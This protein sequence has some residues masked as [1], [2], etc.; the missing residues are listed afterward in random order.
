[1]G[2][3]KKILLLGKDGQVGWELQRALAP[4]G[5]V[6][7]IGR[8]DC[9]LA[10]TSQIVSLVERVRPGAI[11]NP[12]GYTNVDKA[13]SE[14][15]MAYAINATA[16]KVLAAQANLLHIP[17]I[18]FSTDY[19]FDGEKCTPYTEEDTPNPLS[20]Y[21]KTKWQGEKNVAAMCAR[22]VIIRT[23][24]AFGLHGN[25]FLKA[26]LGFARERSELKVVSDQFGAPT[27]ACLLADATAEVLMQLFSD[28]T[29]KYGT[30]HL[31]GGGET[32]WHGYALKIVQLANQLGMKTKIQAEDIQPIPTEKYPLPA[33]RPRSSRLNT[34]KIQEAF[35]IRI[36]HW[37]VEVEDVLKKIIV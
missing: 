19:V 11:V 6:I 7:A 5:E 1:M 30:Y 10:D 33:Q 20:I 3:Y 25:N 26:I 34:Q 36:P 15:E 24:W 12:A 21:G 27:S 8:G 17:I 9:D 37:S 28:E 2:F 16:P 13:E 32:T 22:H 4:L 23:S 35:G 29:G 14:V 18:H 31:A